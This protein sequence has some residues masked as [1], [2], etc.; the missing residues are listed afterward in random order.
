MSKVTAIAFF[1]IGFFTVYDSSGKRILELEHKLKE[2][3]DKF[4][5]LRDKKLQSHQ[6]LEPEDRWILALYIS[7]MFART[8]RQK[9]EGK[10]IWQDYLDLIESLPSDLR[11]KIK[12]TDEYRQV[13]DLHR[14]QPMLYHL[15]NFVN[16]TVPYLA[17]INCAIYETELSPGIITS[18]NPCIWFDPSIYNPNIPMT[19]FWNRVTNAK[20]SISN[21]TQAIY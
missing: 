7:T 19:F 4:I 18:D 9:E 13:L 14:K 6:P 15:F 12:H 2:I 11:E 8:K 1:R 5:A 21:F 17:N 20:Y 3:E 16:L 10:Q